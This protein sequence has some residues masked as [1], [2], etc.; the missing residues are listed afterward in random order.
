MYFF[1]SNQEN[2]IYK[3]NGAMVFSKIVNKNFLNF[4]KFFGT[5]RK[6][7]EREINKQFYEIIRNS[8][9]ELPNRDFIIDLI[10]LDELNIV[11]YMQYLSYDQLK[12]LLSEKIDLANQILNNKYLMRCNLEQDN[13]LISLFINK[14]NYIL[15]S[16]QAINETKYLLKFCD[17]FLLYFEIILQN[18]DYIQQKK[19]KHSKRDNLLKFLEKSEYILFILINIMINKNFNFTKNMP[20]IIDIFSSITLIV[21]FFKIKHSN[22]ICEFQWCIH[23]LSDC[24]NFD[25]KSSMDN[26]KFRVEEKYNKITKNSNLPKYQTIN[27]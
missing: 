10:F 25:L 12:S 5:L 1:I 2:K 4:K 27:N 24:R 13:N 18:I 16:N 14:A 22:K 3:S 17:K 20:F 15:L 9:D 26:L 11:N 21:H 8:L 19:L 6:Q 7:M 23:S